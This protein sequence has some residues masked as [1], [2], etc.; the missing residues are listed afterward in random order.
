MK[1]NQLKKKRDLREI[2]Q[3]VPIWSLKVWNTGRCLTHLVT[4]HN[5][6]AQWQLFS[7]KNFFFLEIF[8]NDFNLEWSVWYKAWDFCKKYPLHGRNI[9]IW[10]VCN[11]CS[12]KKNIV[13]QKKCLVGLKFV[14]YKLFENSAT[15]WEFLWS[16]IISNITKSV[17][18]FYHSF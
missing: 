11:L 3:H 2:T 8:Y 4:F 12:N 1:K 17:K 9:W 10:K 7:L 14:F 15:R 5:I 18:I 16:K 13:N 6:W